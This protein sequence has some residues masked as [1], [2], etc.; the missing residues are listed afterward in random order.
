MYLL[1]LSLKILNI[2]NLDECMNFEVNIANQICCFLQL[3]RP[4][5]QKQDEFQAFKSNLEMNLDALSTNNPF[6]KVMIGNF[7]VKSSNWYLDDITRKATGFK[8]LWVNYCEANPVTSKCQME[9]LDKN[10]KKRSK[11]GK[12]ESDHHHRN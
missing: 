6:L 7:S 9:L 2:S 5:S 11:T 4:P 10:C 1:T 8:S 12:Q 3:Y